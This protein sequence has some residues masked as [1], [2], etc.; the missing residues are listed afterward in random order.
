MTFS[1]HGTARE[2]KKPRYVPFSMLTVVKRRWKSNSRAAAAA[3]SKP[4]AQPPRQRSRTAT[5]SATAAAPRKASAV[6][7]SMNPPSRT[8]ASPS[9]PGRA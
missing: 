5:Q 6:G 4:T 8:M 2:P 7:A 1:G 9:S 3:S